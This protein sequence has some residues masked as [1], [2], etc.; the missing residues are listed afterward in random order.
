MSE[1]GFLISK[2]YLIHSH[3]VSSHCVISN[4]AGTFL[5][6]L[7]SAHWHR[8]SNSGD[9]TLGDIIHLLNVLQLSLWLN[10]HDFNYH[11]QSVL[12]LISNGSNENSKNYSALHPVSHLLFLQIFA[13]TRDN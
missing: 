13:S 7:S 4:E 8:K 12:I 10:Y 5:G 6:S 1:M 2:V 9:Y 3:S 11:I